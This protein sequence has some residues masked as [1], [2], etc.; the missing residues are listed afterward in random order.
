L[1]R[2]VPSVTTVL[3]ILDKPGLPWWGMKIGVEGVLE[4][5]RRG[6]LFQTFSQVGPVS[7]GVA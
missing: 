2:E 1:W 5:V 4:L 7:G 3:G 6:R